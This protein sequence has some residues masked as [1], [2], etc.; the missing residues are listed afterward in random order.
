MAPPP[1]ARRPLRTKRAVSFRKASRGFVSSDRTLSNACASPARAD[2]AQYNP[3]AARPGCTAGGTRRVRAVPRVGRGAS[4]LYRGGADAPAARSLCACQVLVHL[5]LQQQ[6][7]SC[8]R[9]SAP[10]PPARHPTVTRAGGP[11]FA[12][13]AL[14]I[15]AL[16][17]TYGD[18]HAP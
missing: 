9:L 16:C 18:R 11:L 1:P 13:I 5:L 8:E 17:S 12:G 14:M 10:S 6:H 2:A 7:L 15:E 3:D 4:G